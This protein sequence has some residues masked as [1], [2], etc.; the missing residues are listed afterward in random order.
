MKER[1]SRDCFKISEETLDYIL[2]ILQDGVPDA[3][4][5]LDGTIIDAINLVKRRL[6]VCRE[7]SDVLELTEALC[8]LQHLVAGEL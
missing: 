6:H 1:G 3:Q 5:L 4:I 7:A 8:H 2:P